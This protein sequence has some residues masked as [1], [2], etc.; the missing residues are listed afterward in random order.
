MRIG[1][2]EKTHHREAQHTPLINDSELA[3][4][5][6]LDAI[7]FEIELLCEAYYLLAWRGCECLAKLPGFKNFSVVGIRD[8]RNRLIEHPDKKGGVFEWSST[9]VSG[10]GL[11]LKPLPRRT[12]QPAHVDRGFWNNVMTFYADILNHIS[13]LT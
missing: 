12:G 9:Y 8:V 5:R 7:M 3:P 11:K 10:I 2:L 1:R 6:R 4:S 13:R